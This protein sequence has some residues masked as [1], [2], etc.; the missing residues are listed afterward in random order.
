MLDILVMRPEGEKHGHVP[1]TR[2]Q[3]LRR[4]PTLLVVRAGHGRG[5]LPAYKR[6]GTRFVGPPS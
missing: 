6:R 5:A 4:S 3:A 1:S 2:A